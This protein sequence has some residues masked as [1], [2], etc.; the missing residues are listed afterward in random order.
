M[1][2]SQLFAFASVVAG[3]AKDHGNELSNGAK[4]IAALAHVTANII[5]ELGGPKAPP[6]PPNVH[7]MFADADDDGIDDRVDVDHGTL[8][9]VTDE[10]IAAGFACKEFTQWFDDADSQGR[11]PMAAVYLAMCHARPKVRA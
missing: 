5:Q 1:K 10:M 3:I 4:A 2:I 8:P 7:A 9:A 11:F 6:A